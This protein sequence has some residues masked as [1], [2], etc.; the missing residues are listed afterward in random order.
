MPGTERGL[1]G[2][3]D[4]HRLGSGGGNDAFGRPILRSVARRSPRCLLRAERRIL[5]IE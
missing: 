4:A 3:R 5:G 1:R 2:S